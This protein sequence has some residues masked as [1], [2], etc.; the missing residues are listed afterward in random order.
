MSSEPGGPA[1][2]MGIAALGS[3]PHPL[4]LAWAGLGISLAMGQIVL[5]PIEIVS[6][7]GMASLDLHAPC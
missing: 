4:A 5:L 1:L 7:A 2:A 3:C 6:V